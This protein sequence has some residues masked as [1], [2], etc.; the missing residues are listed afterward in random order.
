MTKGILDAGSETAKPSEETEIYG[1]IY[2]YIRHPQ[3][4]GEFPIFVAIGFF[5]NSLTMVVILT[6][7]V[8]IY[9]PIM[10]HY[11]GK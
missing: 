3:S 6:L 8:V 11:E 10:I 2:G 7:F 9:V 1:G 4:L 5:V